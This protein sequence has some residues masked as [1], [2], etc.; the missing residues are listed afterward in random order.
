M[1][2]NSLHFLDCAPHYGGHVLIQSQVQS[3]HETMMKYSSVIIDE[4]S[5]TPTFYKNKILSI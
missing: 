4:H 5:V 1:F 2:I 3:L